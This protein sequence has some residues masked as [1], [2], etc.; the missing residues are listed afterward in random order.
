MFLSP[1]ETHYIITPRGFVWNK[2]SIT[3]W[4]S[5]YN[6]KFTSVEFNKL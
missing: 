5:C 6:N 4:L 2:C 3:H 1:K